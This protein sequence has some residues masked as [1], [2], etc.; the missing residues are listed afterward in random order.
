MA[1]R[2]QVEEWLSHFKGKQR[3]TPLM[4]TS[5]SSS[6]Q[7]AV[8]LLPSEQTA[9]SLQSELPPVTET[10]LKKQKTWSLW[11]QPDP[12]DPDLPTSSESELSE[13]QVA[14]PKG[15]KKRAALP[16]KQGGAPA[17]VA[18]PPMAVTGTLPHPLSKVAVRTAPQTQELYKEC[19][20]GSDRFQ[21]FLQV[22][23]SVLAA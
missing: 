15:H 5:I 16:A 19:D 12:F 11:E 4:A 13:A 8:S 14:P 20:L 17:P 3:D 18:D 1:H 10:S 6:K 22:A 7:R 9:G 2:R 23:H 21:E